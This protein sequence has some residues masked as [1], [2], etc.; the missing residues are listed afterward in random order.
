LPNKQLKPILNIK[1][2]QHRLESAQSSGDEKI[3]WKQNLTIAAKVLVTSCWL[4][5]LLM[6]KTWGC[7]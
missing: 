5:K 3:D 1:T 6:D 4:N 2:F 7:L